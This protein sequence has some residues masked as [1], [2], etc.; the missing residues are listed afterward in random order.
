M[1]KLLLIL[2]ILALI[3]AGCGR[4]DQGKVTVGDVANTYNA[5]QELNQ[6]M[7]DPNKIS[8]EDNVENIYTIMNYQGNEAKETV[9]TA[10]RAGIEDGKAQGELDKELIKTSAANN[11]DLGTG[12]MLGYVFGCK[13]VTGNEDKCNDDMGEK[14]QAI[15]VEEMQ[16]QF[17]NMGVTQ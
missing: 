2:P 11:N 6:D 10:I 17:Q 14:Y 5:A 16:K 1:K 8:S 15:M 9:K 4:A 12:Y 7:N 13:A 3:L